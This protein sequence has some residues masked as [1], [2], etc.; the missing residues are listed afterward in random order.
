M[1]VYKS[2][3]QSRLDYGITMYGFS[4]EKNIDLIQSVQNHAARLI[5]G[6]FDSRNCRW[7]YQVKSLNL[8]SYHPWYRRSFSYNIDVWNYSW[9]C[10][11]LPFL[12]H[13]EVWCKWLW[14]QSI[15]YGFIYNYL[16][17]EKGLI[18]ISFFYMDGKLWND[19]QS[20][21]KILSV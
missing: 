6:I 21:Y 9:E 16:H 2:Y 20:L 10:T 1:Q 14:H 8:C 3:T 4:T 15:R 18:E 12:S 11:N 7:N 19:L 17:G 5:T 13:H